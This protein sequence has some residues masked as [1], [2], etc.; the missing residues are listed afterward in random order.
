[1]GPLYAT[2]STFCITTYVTTKIRGKDDE[3]N[4]AIG[5]FASGVLMGVLLKQNLLGMWLGVGCAIAGAVK[6]HSKL[7]NYE[8]FPIND[9]TN[10]PIY[11]D[12]RTPYVNWT[13]YDARPKGW[14][15][16][17]ERKE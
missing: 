7:N 9:R 5:G 4:Y 12:F 1:M 2:A 6:K 10:K 13:L 17:E 16:A 8:F 11:G 3:T 14:V 15:A